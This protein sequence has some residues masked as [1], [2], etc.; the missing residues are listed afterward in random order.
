MSE[1]GFHYDFRWPYANQIANNLTWEEG[2]QMPILHFV[3]PKK[4]NIL[5]WQEYSGQTV[6]Q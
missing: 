4:H 2:G 6:T 1:S 3:M 5:K